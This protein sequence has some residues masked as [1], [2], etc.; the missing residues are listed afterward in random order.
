[1]H[2]VEMLVPLGLEVERDATGSLISNE[3]GSI[4]LRVSPDVEQEEAARGADRTPVPAPVPVEWLVVSDA[5]VSDAGES[6]ATAES[7]FFKVLE[8]SA[9]AP[10]SMAFSYVT[11]PANQKQDDACRDS[12][13][14]DQIGERNSEADG[15]S[16]EM[17]A[18]G[19]GGEDAF[20]DVRD[21]NFLHGSGVFFA[22]KIQT[23]K[24]VEQMEEFAKEAENLRK[25]QGNENIVQIKDH[26]L[27]PESL[28]VVIL[29]ELAVCDLH[30]FL[31]RSDYTLDVTDLLGIW[32]ALVRAVDAA[33]GADMIHRDLKPQNFLLVPASSSFA[34]DILSHAS[35]TIKSDAFKFRLLHDDG[36][37]DVELALE[38]STTGTTHER[39]F[40]LKLTDFGLAQ[41]LELDVSHLSVLGR[42]GTVKYMAPETLQPNQDGVQRFSK[43]VD[44]WALGVI[45]FQ[46]LHDGR[47]P[48][49]RYHARGDVIGA[50]VATAL[51]SAHPEVMKFERTKVWAAAKRRV[52]DK[53]PSTEGGGV[54]S[55]VVRDAMVVALLKTEFLFRMCEICLAFDAVNRATAGDL[56]NWVGRLLDEE[57]WA[58]KM[59]F[60]SDSEMEALVST[61][62]MEDEDARL[63]EESEP[64][65]EADDVDNLVPLSGIEQVF[66]PEILWWSTPRHSSERS[67][68]HSARAAC[69]NRAEEKTG[70]LVSHA[71]LTPLVFDGETGR[72]Q[73]KGNNWRAIT[74]SS[75]SFMKIGAVVF[76]GI[77]GTGLLIFLIRWLVM[78]SASTPT[79]PLPPSSTSTPSSTLPS[80]STFLPSAT[81]PRPP[82]NSSP[83]PSRSP[84]PRPTS[85]STPLATPASTPAPTPPSTPPPTPLTPLKPPPTPQATSL[86]PTPIPAG[87]KG[88]LGKSIM[89]PAI[90]GGDVPC[91]SCSSSGKAKGSCCVV[92]M[93][94]AKHD[95]EP[96]EGISFETATPIF[97]VRLPTSSGVGYRLGLMTDVSIGNIDIRPIMDFVFGGRLWTLTQNSLEDDIPS[98]R[99]AHEVQE[100]I[101]SLVEGYQEGAGGG[102]ER[103]AKVEEI[104]SFLICVFLFVWPELYSSQRGSLRHIRGWSF[105][106]GVLS[107]LLSGAMGIG[108]S[109]W[110]TRIFRQHVSSIS[111]SIAAFGFRPNFWEM[112][113]GFRSNYFGTALGFQEFSFSFSNENLNGYWANAQYHALGIIPHIPTS[114]AKIDLRSVLW[115]RDL[116]V[117]S[118]RYDNYVLQMY[119][120]RYLSR[121]DKKKTEVFVH[122]TDTRVG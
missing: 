16:Q 53:F 85:P 117:S 14:P 56:R 4:C 23:A 79:P 111:A 91:S 67:T 5:V 110:T 108:V 69:G 15:A 88:F 8:V 41:S 76:F 82:E 2:K 106:R 20:L 21:G 119:Y 70:A 96:S 10:E 84:T 81:R 51:E 25:L 50:A 122:P 39:E 109:A 113:L 45:L 38:D 65:S 55:H 47:T 12:E 101:H 59:S 118:N 87:G 77:L 89:I 71:L 35:A 95:Q 27:M 73:K 94:E 74:T 66:F 86:P 30:I 19:V 61:V 98:K 102:V 49:D 121:V 40:V 22:L 72:E 54:M 80:S 52:L 97:V 99:F 28:H 100:I 92:G 9:A 1:M 43:P 3:D 105:S 36:P 33:H 115:L 93:S 13:K 26:E 31:N 46:M 32:H 90:L 48:F 37:G 68:L 78:S 44:V 29:M 58:Q 6:E 75:C 83:T 7:E 60:I 18:A 112:L 34:D 116:M 104:S 62:S 17:P 103:R 11:A 107:H 63:H 42:A 24:N 57:W 114:E 64:A 120:D